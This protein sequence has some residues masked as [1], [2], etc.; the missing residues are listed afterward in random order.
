MR[1]S[2]RLARCSPVLA[3]ALVTACAAQSPAPVAAAAR[4]LF[5]AVQ[6]KDGQAA[7]AALSPRAA[8]SLS[9]GG[10]GCAQE[11]LRLGLRGGPVHDVRVWG[12]RAQLKAGEDTV[13]LVR[14]EGPGWKVAAAGCEPR[15][16]GLPYD[17]DVEA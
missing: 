4:S 1:S 5:A 10:T 11:I 2:A 9:S 6:R 7:C 17:C 16:S 3:V 15:G 14:L 13:F 8:E 12:D